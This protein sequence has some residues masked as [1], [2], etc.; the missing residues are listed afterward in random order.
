MLSN[1]LYNRLK[2]LITIYLPAFG[3]VYWG[4][5]ET[6][7]FEKVS[8]VN[9]TVNGVIAAVGLYLAYSSKKYK[10]TVDRPD[11]ELYVIQDPVDGEFGLKLG[12]TNGPEDLTSKSRVTL[13]VKHVPLE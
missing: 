5:W 2:K 10:K 6:F 4:S 7:D 3:V 11:G 8:N 1:K 12:V 9:G 13:Q